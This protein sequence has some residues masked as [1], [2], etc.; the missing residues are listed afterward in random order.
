[1]D[2]IEFQ[3]QS[4]ND[5]IQM[6]GHGPYVWACY[7]ITLVALVYLAIAPIRKRKSLYNELRRQARIEAHEKKREQAQSSVAE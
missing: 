4:L 6:A 7:L 1:M 3:F 2:Q 5:F